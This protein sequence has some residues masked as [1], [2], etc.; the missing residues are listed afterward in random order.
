LVAA[1]NKKA[2]Q[3]LTPSHSCTPSL[4]TPNSGP[5]T[6]VFRSKEKKCILDKYV[7][8]FGSGYQESIITKKKGKLDHNELLPSLASSWQCMKPSTDKYYQVKELTI[9]NVISIVIREYAAFS[10]NKLS[11]IRLLNT[12]FA[13]M[14]PKLQRWLQID[15]SLLLEP[16][17]NY[18][19][20]MQIDPHQVCM[21]N[22][23]MAHFG[24]DPGRFV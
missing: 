10:K 6:V 5:S 13:K 4:P 19:S 8:K 12:N 15:F 22:A 24:L 21:A 20:Q 16:Q 9:Y 23:A 18:K 7:S 17:L 2:A 1:I 3:S 11:N 14:I